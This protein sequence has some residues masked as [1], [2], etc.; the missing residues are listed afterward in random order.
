MTTRRRRAWLWPTSVLLVGVLGIGTGLALGTSNATPDVAPAP[1]EVTA[2]VRAQELRDWAPVECTIA[3]AQTTV[4]TPP[5]AEGSLPIVTKSPLDGTVAHEGD[6]LLEIAGRP[7]ILLVGPHPLYRTLREGD[8]GADVKILQQALKRLGRSVVVDG[9]FGSGT[10]RSLATVYRQRGYSAPAE[11]SALPA[12]L[13]VGPESP[14]HLSNP[15]PRVGETLG[16]DLMVYYTG[17][18]HGSCS[19]ARINEIQVGDAVEFLDENGSGSVT[20]IANAPL[21]EGEAA[22][23]RVIVEVASESAA[24]QV[25]QVLRGRVTVRRSEG[26]VLSV[27]VTAV[28]G[29]AGSS[30][31]VTVVRGDERWP[32]P[33]QVG[34]VVD[35]Y[36]EVT[37]APEAL[38]DGD[39]V[40]VGT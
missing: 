31:M 30:P 25:G 21:A 12:E 10:A 40:V 5:V 17:S 35:G 32:I 22:S 7:V 14:L 29:G 4:A 26:P 38:R 13:L 8:E 15:L 9:R 2:A 24:A 36:A 23:R 37:A 33:V 3:R 27:P 1:H 18:A 19:S 6:V 11:N 28:Q 16:T 20:E 34:L 39:I